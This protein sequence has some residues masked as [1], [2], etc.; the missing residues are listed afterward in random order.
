MPPRRGVRHEGR[1]PGGSKGD[2]VTRRSHLAAWLLLWLA[3]L[4]AWP[5]WTGPER[6]AALAR[7]ESASVHRTF[8]PRVGAWLLEAAAE[9][10]R[11]VAGDDMEDAV[12]GTTGATGGAGAHPAG[13]RASARA[14]GTAASNRYLP[15]ISRLVIDRADRYLDSLRLQVHGAVLRALGLAAWTVMLLPL[16]LAAMADGFAQRRVKAATFG[17]QNPAA[18]ALSLHALIAIAMLPWMALVLPVPLPAWAMPVW[19]VVAMLPL[20]MAVTHLQ[21]VFTR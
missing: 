7:D 17:Y 19:G 18:F 1:W 6:L 10:Q 2:T 9:V 15:V 21:P 4:V 12:H 20:R 13:A 14:S 8:G 3:S 5:L 11:A 16:W